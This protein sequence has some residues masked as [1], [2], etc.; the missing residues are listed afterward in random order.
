M[1]NGSSN[2]AS[3]YDLWL[4]YY[5]EYNIKY[6]L[7]NKSESHNRQ[8]QSF[9]FPLIVVQLARILLIHILARIINSYIYVYIVLLRARFIYCITLYWKF[10]PQL[11]QPPVIRTSRVEITMHTHLLKWTDHPSLCNLEL[12]G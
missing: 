12:S 7:H 10:R 3:D 5:I 1:S 8:K 4:L 2:N 9:L 6:R 11:I